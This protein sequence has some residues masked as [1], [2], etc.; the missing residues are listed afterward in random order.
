MKHVDEF[1]EELLER[2]WVIEEAQQEEMEE[3]DEEEPE[4]PENISLNEF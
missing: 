1:L 4:D 3:E 2:K